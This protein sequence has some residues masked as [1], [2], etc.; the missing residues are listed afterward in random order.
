MAVEV[1]Q[2]SDWME[3]PKI[4]RRRNVLHSL[5]WPAHFTLAQEMITRLKLTNFQLHK[6]LT[7]KLD[8]RIT[9][10]VGESDTGKSAL[11]RA[12][13]W[14]MLNRPSGSSFI[15]KGSGHGSV[16]LDIDGMQ[17]T[18]HRSASDNLYKTRRRGRSRVEQ[19]RSFGRA[20]VPDPIANLLKVT[21]ANFQG[22]HDPFYW[23]ALSPPQVSRE[24][25]K[26]V[27]LDSID[28]A[29]AY[30]SKRLRRLSTERDV[31]RKR[32]TTARQAKKDLDW[33]VSADRKLRALEELEAEWRRLSSQRARLSALVSQGENIRDAK[34]R[35]GDANLKALAAVSTLTQVEGLR[36][37][38]AKLKSLLQTG[39]KLAK[40]PK[41]L[42]KELIEETRQLAIAV[43]RQT[44]RIK[45]LEVLLVTLTKLEE[46]KTWL[47]EKKSNLRRKLRGTKCPTCG[48]TMS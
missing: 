3:L 47:L 17:I 12:L 44:G 45:G 2:S 10:I 8:P 15:R 22:Q 31:C 43:D 7:V 19:Y 41:P 29:L 26:I 20:N 1:I 38:V 11:F 21:E 27:D 13:R 18:R 23:L 9:T 40:L 32:M 39:G 35:L 6:K 14:L 36:K 33:A 48:R 34:E 16:V 25:N 42:S 37:G 24:L 46:K 28:H 4:S 5:D 30:V